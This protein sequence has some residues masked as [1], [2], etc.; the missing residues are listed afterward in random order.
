VR[1]GGIA[2]RGAARTV[3]HHADPKFLGGAPNQ[4]LTRLA[5]ATHKNLHRDLNDFLLTRTDKFG[6]HMRLQR[7]NSGQDIR[8]NFSRQERL[9]ALRD[10]YRGP[11][12]TYTDAARDFFRQHTGL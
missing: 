3:R 6:N 10:F 2:A 1:G 7:G 5:E 4:S 9:E 11:G 8:Q 12:A